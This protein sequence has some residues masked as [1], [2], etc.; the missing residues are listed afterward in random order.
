MI[1]GTV[2][3]ELIWFQAPPT[4]PP[5]VGR[6][7]SKESE[8]SCHHRTTNQRVG[9]ANYQSRAQFSSEVCCDS[10]ESENEDQNVPWK[11]PSK[12]RKVL[13]FR[14]WRSPCVVFFLGFHSRWDKKLSE[15]DEGIRSSLK[16][17]KAPPVFFPGVDREMI[18]STDSNLPKKRQV[19]VRFGIPPKKA[20]LKRSFFTALESSA[21]VFGERWDLDECPDALGKIG[22]AQDPNGVLVLELI[23][24]DFFG[25]KTTHN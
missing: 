18:S 13:C 8:T 22:W 20:G 16:A 10:G 5:A 21:K 14:L 3:Y 7:L 11:K 23:W 12:K 19:Q 6:F 17:L 15:V 9:I 24:N 2:S 4:E 1:Y 25:S